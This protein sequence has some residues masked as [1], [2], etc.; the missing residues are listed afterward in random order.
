[1]INRPVI[2]VKIFQE[3]VHASQD[4]AR[5]RRFQPPIAHHV[6]EDIPHTLDHIQIVDENVVN[7]VAETSVDE[8]RRFQH[9]L[10]NRITHDIEH[11]FGQLLHPRQLAEIVQLFH[12]QD[13]AHIEGRQHLLG[14]V[15]GILRQ[16]A[17]AATGDFLDELFLYG[18]VPRFRVFAE[19]RLLDEHLHIGGLR[20][21]PHRNH[22][23]S[24]D[25]IVRDEP[26]MLRHEYKSQLN[27]GQPI[28]VFLD[29]T[30][31][32]LEE[33]AVNRVEVLTDDD[34]DF[35]VFHRDRI[36]D[37]LDHVVPDLLGITAEEPHID[38]VVD[39]A[40]LELVG[41]FL[42]LDVHLFVVFERGRAV[43]LDGGQ[44]L[45]ILA[46]TGRAVKNEVGQLVNRL[47][48][49]EGRYQV[50]VDVVMLDGAQIFFVFG[51]V[52]FHWIT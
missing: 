44:H 17:A 2:V 15:H 6:F 52:V 20:R 24:I 40:N 11:L 27:R 47:G 39:V 41:V 9:L 14:L 34:A 23:A 48:E 32:N 42:V 50:G 37:L 7:G 13:I 4:I 36:H 45:R 49:A 5:I 38:L 51:F 3:P 21:P 26:Q 35:V 19:F 33:L 46:G 31:E 30:V 10:N 1:M 22:A 28:P 12:V 25:D 43:T 16:N 18:G 29:I 8:F